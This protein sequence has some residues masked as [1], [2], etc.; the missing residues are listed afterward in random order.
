MVEY[1]I[2]PHNSIFYLFFYFFPINR[3]YHQFLSYNPP[4]TTQISTT[5]HH[6]PLQTT[7]NPTASPTYRCSPLQHI[8]KPIATH[9]NPIATQQKTQTNND[10]GEIGRVG[11]GME[12]KF[13]GK[14]GIQTDKDPLN[15]IWSSNPIMAKS[16]TK[17]MS[18]L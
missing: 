18:G 6:E 1:G 3:T 5:H 2:F 11:K 9:K 14:S 17:G 7:P 10:N 8:P 16:R 15:Q 13:N 12:N 4:S